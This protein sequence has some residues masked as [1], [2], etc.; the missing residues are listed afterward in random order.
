MPHNVLYARL[1]E[2]SESSLIHQI[3]QGPQL[4]QCLH[5]QCERLDRSLDEGKVA[6]VALEKA[7]IRGKAGWILPSPGFET[8]VTDTKI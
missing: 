2:R 1:F 3:K 5:Q 4:L 8:S 7:M 6:I